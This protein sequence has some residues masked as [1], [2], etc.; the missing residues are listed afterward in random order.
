MTVLPI[1]GEVWCPFAK[2]DL[3]VDAG[4]FVGGPYRGVLHTTEGK[5]Y[6][7]AR[8][9]YADHKVA[10]HFTKGLGFLFQHIR[11]DRAA[12]ALQNPPGGV[13]TNR[14]GAIQVEVVAS[15]AHPDWTDDLASEV[16]Q[17][18]VWIEGQTGI[19]PWS[20]LFKAYRAGDPPGVS[21]YGLKNGVRMSVD[22]WRR[23]DGWCGHQHVPENVHGDPGAIPIQRLLE[24]GG[25]V[26]TKIISA[27]PPRLILVRPQSDG[28]W[29]VAEDGGVFAFG[30]A[31]SLTA[32]GGGANEHIV[33]GS[34]WPDGMGLLL[35]GADGGV[36]ALGSAEYL[37]RVWYPS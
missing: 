36:F 23:F 33:A 2:R 19:K 14:L 1:V 35:M 34:V 9:V 4:P 3:F 37:D 30:N 6:A 25:T 21:A 5:S 15:A 8:D 20:P 7:S 27:M 24:R 18:M 32:I 29:I 22:S 31:P 11:L 17:L 26:G 12:R 13:E 28:Y 10:P 16:Q